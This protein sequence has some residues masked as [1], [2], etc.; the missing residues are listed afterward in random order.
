M[1]YGLAVG[2][3]AGIKI[4]DSGMMPMGWQ[5]AMGW[6]WIYGLAFG[7]MSVGPQADIRFCW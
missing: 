4:G 2:L 7:I 5:W 1:G 6:Q 3:W